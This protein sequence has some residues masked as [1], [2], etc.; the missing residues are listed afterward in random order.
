MVGAANAF[1]WRLELLRM[2]VSQRLVPEKRQTRICRGP[3]C[4]LSLLLAGSFFAQAQGAAPR[5][6]VKI[7]A[8]QPTPAPVPALYDGGTMRSASGHEIGLNSRYLTMD[9]RPWLPVAGEFHFSRVPR[10]EW[11]EQL[12]KMKDS[13]V[14]IVATYIIWIHHEEKRGEFDWQGQKD[15]RAFAE[16]CQKH[17]LYLEPRVGPWAHAEVRNGGLP[18]WVASMPRIRENDPAYLDAVRSFYAQIATQLKGLMWKDGGPVISMQLENEYAK[19][20][21]GAGEE[22]IRTLKQMAREVGFDVPLY[23]VTGWDQAVVPRPE[24]LPVYGGGYPD[25]PWNEEITKLPAPEVYAFRF[26]SRV[27]ANMGAIGGKGAGAEDNSATMGLPYMTAEIGGG[28]ED[29]YHRRPVIHP[30]D[31]GAMFPVMLGSGVNLYGSYM[32]QGGQNP[33]GRFTTLQES[34]RT[35]YPNDLP[36]KSYDFQAPLGQY[37][38]ERESLRKMKLYQ[39]F[40]AAFG[41][42]LAP[43][44][45]HGP[46]EMPKSVTDLGVIRAS[47]RTDGNAGFLFVNNY[48]R[49]EKMPERKATQFALALPQGELK[50]PAHPIDIPADSYFIWPFGQSFAGVG[51]RYATAQLFT[52]LTAGD[53]KVIYLAATDGIPVELAFDA[54]TVKDLHSTS[55]TIERAEALVRVSR[56]RPGINSAIDLLSPSGEKLRFVVL[57]AKE[58]ED[59][60]R[61]QLEGAVHL[62][63]TAADV[64]ADGDQIH[65]RQR[66]NAHF[67]FA[68]TPALKRTPRGTLAIEAGQDGH[69]S[70]QA[71]GQS[72]KLEARLEQKPGEVPPVPLG[73]KVSWRKAGVAQAPED[74]DFARAARYELALPEE[75]LK[76]LSNLFLQI[77]YTGDVARLSENGHL[78]DDNFFNGESWQIGLKRYAHAGKLPKLE[79]QVL[80]LRK[81]AP[82]YFELGHAAHF[83]VDGQAATLEHLRLVPEYGL[84]LT[85]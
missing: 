49:G 72:F 44:V 3:A 83:G 13:G 18:D 61:V 60:W 73:P 77:D 54:A 28:I 34:Q 1:H 5:T 33:D 14:N 43:M 35:G 7:D 36:V 23:V 45:A 81:D 29:T 4:I 64:A 69:Y 10:A 52:E 55:G 76:G 25:A 37:G 63:V 26:T 11:E 58:A 30:N 70:A 17:G 31:I 27:A 53:R 38:E 16:L 2:C 19:R 6:L 32:Y 62:L 68:V 48:V 59:A 74:A 12:I 40:T 22:H 50:L 67:D 79:L 56:I 80:P 15:L 41:D 65:L 46:A 8:S 9:G 21:T 42:R 78:L 24:V 75:G 71:A 20:G 85:Q 39:Y 82:V 47:V 84:D 66:G 57:T 51:L